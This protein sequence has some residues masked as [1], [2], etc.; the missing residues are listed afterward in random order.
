MR[1]MKWIGWPIFTL[2]VA[3]L[4]SLFIYDKTMDIGTIE[5]ESNQLSTAMTIGKTEFEDFPD[6]TIHFEHE[7]T[8]EG[9]SY[10]EW[11]SFTSEELN[12]KVVSWVKRQ[13]EKGVE[14]LSL[15]QKDINHHFY[16]FILLAKNN[17][18]KEIFP[19]VID[20]NEVKLLSLGELFSIN[21]EFIHKL[22]ALVMEA[23]KGHMDEE[24]VQEK[25]ASIEDLLW[26]IDEE[27]LT[28]YLKDEMKSSEL[29]DYKVELPLP[30]LLSFA[31]VE[32]IQRNSLLAGIVA[33]EAANKAEEERMRREAEE[34]KRLEEERKHAQ[35][36]RPSGN[37]GKYVA[38]TFD[39]GPHEQVTPRVLDTLKKYGAKGTFFMLGT[40][41]NKYPDIV[42]RIAT[43]GHELGNHSHNHPDLTKLDYGSVERH[44]SDTRSTIEQITGI[45]T[46]LFRPPYGAVNGN[47]LSAAGN[48]GSSIIL[49]SVDSL[50]WDSRNAHSIYNEVMQNVKGGSIVLMHDLYSSTADALERILKTL[51]DQGFEFVTVSELLQMGGRTGTGPHRGV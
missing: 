24:F 49:W 46:S 51:K 50:D 47:V 44:F 48:T 32:F 39:D 37:V 35:Q 26:L 2:F 13:K 30:E 28:V 43:E 4:I 42:K 40:E 45:N 3:F 15:Q 29:A 5:A 17:N 9:A 22:H 27:T 7:I 34:R 41:V 6:L 8:D 19:F 38:F 18:I 11:P 21:D 23:T 25:L 20:K 16:Q 33:E 31:K 36:Q 1:Y 14:N 12:N 10:Y